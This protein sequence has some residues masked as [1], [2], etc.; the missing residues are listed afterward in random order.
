[1]TQ[2]VFDVE[3]IAETVNIDTMS[4]HGSDLDEEAL[5]R[6]GGKI[7]RNSQKLVKGSEQI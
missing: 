2:D 3:M 1:M 6:H 4:L 7:S 5:V